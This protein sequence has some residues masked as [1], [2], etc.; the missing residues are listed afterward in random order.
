VVI[1]GETKLEL[2]DAIELKIIP[3]GDGIRL[4]GIPYGMT[5]SSRLSFYCPTRAADLVFEEYTYSFTPLFLEHSV[6][7]SI[8]AGAVQVDSVSGLLLGMTETSAEG[9]YFWSVKHN[10]AAQ[11]LS[12]RDASYGSDKVMFRK[13]PDGKWIA[14]DYNAAHSSKSF[15]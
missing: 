4:T 7:R 3:E 1:R 2:V 8:R 6:G 13:Q 14:A 9:T 11:A 12:G 5:S 10:P 15:D